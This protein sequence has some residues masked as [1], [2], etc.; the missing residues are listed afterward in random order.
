[1]RSLDHKK[2]GPKGQEL[3]KIEVRIVEDQIE[4]NAESQSEEKP[5]V[6]PWDRD[7]Q[8]KI[9]YDGQLLN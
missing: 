3:C 8:A 4:G 1:M 9:I 7:P 5:P 6:D 2:T